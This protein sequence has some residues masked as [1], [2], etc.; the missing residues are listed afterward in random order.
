VFL[1]LVSKHL[2][3]LLRYKQSQY[4]MSATVNGATRGNEP[5]CN[6]SEDNSKCLK[7]LLQW[8]DQNKVLHRWAEIPAE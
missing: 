3:G 4:Q 6:L 7:G 2:Q 5:D 8:E 1:L